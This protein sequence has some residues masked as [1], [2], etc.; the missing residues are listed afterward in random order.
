MPAQMRAAEAAGV[1]DV[2]E[3]ALDVTP[4]APE[5]PLPAYA[6]HAPAIARDGALRLRHRR[7]VPSAT[8]RLG[9]VRPHRDC[10]EI[11]QRLVAVI[12]LV[13]DDLGQLRRRGARSVRGLDLFRGG[14]GGFYETRRASVVASIG[15]ARPLSSPAGTK[16]SCTQV[17]AA[18]WVST[19]INRRV[20]EIVE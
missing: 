20:R 12:S 6:T 14:N 8:I 10:R 2:G 15:T 16:R 17:N 4:A 19:A 5:Q 13:R 9:D 18:R 1:I 7:P 3:G 11:H